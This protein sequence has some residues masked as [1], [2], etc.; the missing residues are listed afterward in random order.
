MV[1]LAMLTSLVDVL[2]LA[3]SLWLGIYL[4]THEPRRRSS[5]LAGL[6]L[7]SLSGYFLDGF[8]HLN[9]PPTGLFDWWMGWSVL[10]TAPLWLDLSVL[11]SQSGGWQR[12]VV[13]GSYTLALALLLVELTSGAAFGVLS[14]KPFVYASAQQAGP[15]YPLVCLLMIASPTLAAFIL[16]QGW[17]GS[18]R[19]VWRRQLGLLALSTLLATASSAYLTLAVWFG[20]DVPL[21]WGHIL[22]GTAMALLGYN[23]ARYSALVE[24]LGRQVD[25]TY[26]AAAISLVVIL[27]GLVAWLS[28]LVFDIPLSVFIFVLVLVILSHSLYEWGGARLERLFYRRQYLRLKADLHAF[29][30]EAQDRDLSEQFGLMLESVCRAVEAAWGWI[31]LFGAGGPATAAA[32]PAAHRQ[33]DVDAAAL[34]VPEVAI[35]GDMV[36]V[37]LY[38][39]H[40]QIG[41]VLLGERGNHRAYTESDLDLLDLSADQLTSVV[42]VAHQQ[43]EMVQQIDALVSE[44]RQREKQLRAELQAAM[45]SSQPPTEGL[46]AGENDMRTLVEDAIRHLYDYVY[47]G[48]HALAQLRLVEQ[49][50]GRGGAIT[51]LDRGKALNQVLVEV[52]EKL[53]PRDLPPQELTR[54]WIQ[55]VILHDAYVQGEPNRDIMNKLYISESSFNRA[56]RRAIMGVARAVEDMEAEQVPH[57][58]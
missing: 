28:Y 51:H 41:V 39:Q 6:T 19:S 16:F 12:Y 33:P 15:L 8:L 56:R 43:R 29:A 14:G 49:R 48:G 1:D 25:F 18:A 44:F 9:P 42:Y 27:Y 55:Y 46:S 17:R 26:S 38:V 35:L 37:P 4:V 7:W 31:E 52:I 22:L 13:W 20:W 10:F 24:G 47:L 34:R 54:E 3:L 57:V 36:V 11:L 40:E 45:E 2:A 23:V 30:R 32:Y 58:I 5:W 21:L 50:L 53:R